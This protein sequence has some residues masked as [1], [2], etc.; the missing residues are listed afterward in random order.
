MAITGIKSLNYGVDDVAECARFFDDFGLRAIRKEDA[1]CRFK[2]PEGSE[3]VIRHRDDPALPVSSLVGDGVREVIWGVDTQESLDAI[4][5]DLSSDREVTRG[6]DGVARF[7]TDFGLAM[8]LV[9]FTRE[10]TICAPDP[11]NA[12]GHVRRLNQHRKWRLR[13]NPKGIAHVVFAIPHY[14]EGSAF[15]RDRLGFRLSDNQ[16][17]FGMYLRADGTNNHHN[18]LLLNASAPFPGMDGKH[19]FHHANFAV[20]DIDEIMVGANHMVRQGWEP[21]HLGL[22]RHRIDSALFYYLPCPAGGEAEYG[23]DADYVDESWVPREWINP[24]FAYSHFVHNLPP[25]LAKP[26]AWDFRYI[27]GIEPSDGQH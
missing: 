6:S 7:V 14:E 22:G 13:A 21:S 9:V 8:G 10:P 15:M 27:T 1:V 11:V 2:L 20:E 17:G 5:V 26:P 23:A 19:R 25:F 3:V 18:L 16:R 12:P 24:L 4:V